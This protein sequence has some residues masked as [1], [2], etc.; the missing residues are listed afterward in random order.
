[1]S[2]VY[3]VVLGGHFGGNYQHHPVWGC[4]TGCVICSPSR[5]GICL[6]H[7]PNWVVRRLFS[8]SKKTGAERDRMPPD[9]AYEGARV[10]GAPEHV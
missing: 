8:N 1:M 10:P 6:S 5:V 9:R 2:V 7:H 3:R 4:V